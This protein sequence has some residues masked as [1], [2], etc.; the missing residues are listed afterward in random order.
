LFDHVSLHAAGEKVRVDFSNFGFSG[1][2]SAEA[3]G[4]DDF[5]FGEGFL[6]DLE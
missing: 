5:G 1:S 2:G 3:E 4:D 6:D